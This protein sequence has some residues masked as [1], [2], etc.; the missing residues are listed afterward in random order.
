MRDLNTDELTALEDELRQATE[1]LGFEA[2][3]FKIGWYNESVGEKFTLPYTDDTLAF[4]IVSQPSMFEKAFLPFIA[5]NL[6]DLDQVS[7]Q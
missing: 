2:H 3:P 5:E 4:V 1:N 7:F 6:E